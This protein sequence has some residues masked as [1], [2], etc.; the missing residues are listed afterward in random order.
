MHAALLWLRRYSA[1]I[2]YDAACTLLSVEQALGADIEHILK[3]Q[4][5]VN[6]RRRACLQLENR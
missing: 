2:Q 3:A 4:A 5:M 1:A 6:A